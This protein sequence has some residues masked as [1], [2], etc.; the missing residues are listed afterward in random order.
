MHLFKFFTVF[1][2]LA[3]LA[4][5]TDASPNVACI[6]TDLNKLAKLIVLTAHVVRD[7]RLWNTYCYVAGSTMNCGRGC[8]EREDES[9]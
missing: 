2:T 7:D 3:V 9:T 4:S 8:L 6:P 1:S 5:C